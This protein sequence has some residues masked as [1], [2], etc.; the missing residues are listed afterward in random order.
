[1]ANAAAS[2]SALT[3]SAVFVIVFRI[4][5]WGNTAGGLFRKKPLA[6]TKITVFIIICR[7]LATEMFHFLL[8][9][10]E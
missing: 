8:F 9:Q 2:T 7:P 1:V 3:L 10:C 4:L 6:A 5:C